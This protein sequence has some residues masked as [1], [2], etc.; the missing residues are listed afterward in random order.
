MWD[1]LYS[2]CNLFVNLILFFKTMFIFKKLWYFFLWLFKHCQFA[3]NLSLIFY[4]YI[5]LFN[6]LLK[7][8]RWYLKF[9]SI[10]CKF[11]RYVLQTSTS[12]QNEII[13]T[14][15]IFLVETTK[16]QKQTTY[17]IVVLRHWT[18]LMRD[19]D[20]K[21]MGNRGSEPYNRPCLL[22]WESIQLPEQRG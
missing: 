7:D 22:P 12:N 13:G 6:F 3:Y 15:F 21:E 14:G 20:P 10:S 11:K 2:L 18:S 1:S 17:E 16:R 8:T 4:F 5:V 19:T 9:H